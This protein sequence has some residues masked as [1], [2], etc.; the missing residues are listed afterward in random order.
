MQSQ[1]LAILGALTSCHS[2]WLP[3]TLTKTD[4]TFMAREQSDYAGKNAVLGPGDRILSYA[5]IKTRARRE[6]D[7]T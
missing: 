7:L 3:D 6:W 1:P 4:H 2:T 5:M